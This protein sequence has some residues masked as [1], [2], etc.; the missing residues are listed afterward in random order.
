MSQKVTTRKNPECYLEK[1]HFWCE[2]PTLYLKIKVKK[3]CY[4]D[5]TLVLFYVAAVEGSM[6]VTFCDMINGLYAVNA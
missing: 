1:F 5:V 2:F 4:L 6:G 3:G